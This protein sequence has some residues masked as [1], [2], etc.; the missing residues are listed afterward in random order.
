M[1]DSE[2]TALLKWALPRLGR[3]Y[4][5]Y[6]NVRG[7]VEKRIRRRVAALGLSSVAEYRARLEADL[8]EWA[9]L[10]R[11]CFVTISRFYRDRKV[12]EALRDEVLP[13]QAKS[14][15][16]EYEERFRVLCTGAASG[17]EPYTLSMLWALELAERYPRL[18][19]DIVATDVDERVLERA[20]VAV[21]RRGLVA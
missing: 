12:W 1:A 21:L 13:A 9:E 18:S 8:E 3:R 7:Q 14:A 2:C 11:L 4:K 10:D 5:G 15:E 16:I 17:E 19:L 6:E 20:R